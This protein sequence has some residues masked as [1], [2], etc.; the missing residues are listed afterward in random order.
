[1]KIKLLTI[2]RT[3]DKMMREAVENYCRRVSHYVPF[4]Y[5]TLP[6]VKVTRS[7]T[8]DKQKEMEGERMLAMLGAGDRL[9]LLDERG[10]MMTSRAFAV[11]I[12]KMMTSLQRDLV[13][14][15]GGPYGFSAEVY[16]RADA[17]L[18]LT[19]MTM[20]HE[21]VR[22]FFVEQLYRAMTI[23]RGEPYHHD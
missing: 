9:V 8:A 15:I 23:I 22:L 20:T 7:T 10:K 2:G 3:S 1:M 11:D 6:D 18:S 4:E 14:A 12:E 17:M 13:F 5:V 19:P 21:M 16:K